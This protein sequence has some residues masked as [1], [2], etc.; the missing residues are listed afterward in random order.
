V[1]ASPSVQVEALARFTQP[2]VLSQLSSV[3]GLPS[4]HAVA[5]PGRHWLFAHESP[6]VQ[7]SPSVQVEALARFTQPAV[8]S[9][10]SSVQGFPSSQPPSTHLA[11]LS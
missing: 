2:A 1:Q 4:S 5:W 6:T 3:Q 11:T 9:Q 7:A 8:L 10:L